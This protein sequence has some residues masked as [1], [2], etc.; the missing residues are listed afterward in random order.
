MTGRLHESLDLT[1]ARSL[2]GRTLDL[3]AAD[4][5]ILTSKCSR[6]CSVLAVENPEGFKKLFISNVLPFGASAAVYAFNRVARAIHVIGERLFGL[7]WS[8][9]YDD[10][11][12]L[13]LACCGDEAQR[14]AERLLSLLGWRFS[15][16]DSKR[17]P[18]DFCFDVLGVTFELELQG[19]YHD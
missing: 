7:V 10:Y 1:K 15:L 12:Q 2:R 11:H 18:M 14:T 19:T 9:Y 17:K 6:W 16:K 5:Q 13:D 3:D 8:N 4:K